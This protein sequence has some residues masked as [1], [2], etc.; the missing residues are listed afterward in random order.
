MFFKVAKLLSG[1]FP[2]ASGPKYFIEIPSLENLGSHPRCVKRKKCVGYQSS[3]TL[4][5][6]VWAEKRL[7]Y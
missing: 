5:F 7:K 3:F 1:F 2:Y 4:V 6:F